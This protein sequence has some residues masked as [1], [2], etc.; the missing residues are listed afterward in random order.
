MARARASRVQEPSDIRLS[1]SLER[2]QG[3][4]TALFSWQGRFG[5]RLESTR[6]GFLFEIASGA[7]FQVS[8]NGSTI[9]CD[10]SP[11]EWDKKAGE[12]FVRRILPR[13]ALLRGRSVLHAAS[14]AAGE[15]SIL[16]CG[17][18]GI[19]KST[20]SLYLQE[21]LGWQILHDDM[22]VLERQPDGF[23]THFGANCA[24]LWQDSKSELET[25]IEN[26]SLLEAYKTKFRCHAKAPPS[27]LNAPLSTIYFL[28]ENQLRMQLLDPMQALKR[29][30][31]QQI[32]I[33]PA[34][35]NERRQRFNVL[36][37]IVTSTRAISLAYPRN[38]TD[39]PK[40]AHALIEDT[41]TI[42]PS[43]QTA[44]P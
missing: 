7:K 2:Y 43:Q 35:D 32:A 17:D 24:S 20:L 11:D 27:I 39:L 12:A 8:K 10:A 25:V 18:S 9:I 44:T 6:N 23:H 28:E 15:S 37:Q 14:L 4:S 38:Y 5:L 1:F 41:K 30:I 26:A 31:R 19:G 40:V 21:T 16:L 13:V 22:S 3:K 34:D 36:T 33:N 29:L 42:A